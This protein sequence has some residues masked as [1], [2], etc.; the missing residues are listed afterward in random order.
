MT[1]HYHLTEYEHPPMREAQMLTVKPDS[2][3]GSGLLGN[4]RVLRLNLSATPGRMPMLGV[5]M[6]SLCSTSSWVFAI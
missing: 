2:V 5:L 6:L 1:L 4:R 3:D